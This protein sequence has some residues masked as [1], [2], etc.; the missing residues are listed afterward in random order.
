MVDCATYT[1]LQGTNAMQQQTI[2]LQDDAPRRAVFKESSFNNRCRPFLVYYNAD[3]A[4]LSIG[5]Q[6]LQNYAH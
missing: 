4:V 2:R 3:V 5:F 1:C 6:A